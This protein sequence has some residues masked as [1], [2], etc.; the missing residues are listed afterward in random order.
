[1]K[2]LL[3]VVVAVTTCGTL[4]MGCGGSKTA[5]TTAAAGTAESTTE[6]TAAGDTAASG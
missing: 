4:L 6:S 5:A 1:M 2:K 3:S